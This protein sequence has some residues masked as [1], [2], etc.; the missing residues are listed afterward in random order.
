MNNEQSIILPK[1]YLSIKEF[2]EASGFTMASD[3][4]TGSLLRTLAVTKPASK[5][6]ELA[7]RSYFKQSCN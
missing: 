5:F 2:T 7:K 3:I 1:E 4:L 6:L